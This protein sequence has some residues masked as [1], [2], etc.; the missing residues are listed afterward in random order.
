MNTSYKRTV[1]LVL[2]WLDSLALVGLGSAL[3]YEIDDTR[4]S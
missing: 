4:I 3:Y 2:S 1:G